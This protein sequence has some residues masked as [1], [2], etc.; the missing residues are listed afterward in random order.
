MTVRG[1]WN[2]PVILWTGYAEHRVTS[3]AE[4]ERL[5]VEDWPGQQ[6]AL[7]I[8]AYNACAAARETG[9]HEYAR[10]AFLRVARELNLVDAG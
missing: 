3:T 6:S 8:Q 5:L 9:N 10:R 7:Y 1:W 4:A 2:R